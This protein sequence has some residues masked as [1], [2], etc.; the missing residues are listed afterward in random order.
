MHFHPIFLALLI[1]QVYIQ[2]AITK[3]ILMSIDNKNDI[4]VEKGKNLI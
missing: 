3:F 1:C 2:N 4:R